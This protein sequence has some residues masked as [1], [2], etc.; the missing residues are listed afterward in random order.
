MRSITRNTALLIVTFL[1]TGVIQAADVDVKDIPPLWVA[2]HNAVKTVRYKA[3]GTQLFTTAML[4]MAERAPQQQDIEVAEAFNVLFD[5]Q[6]GR[7]RAE[8]NTHAAS[9]TGPVIIPLAQTYAYNGKQFQVFYPREENTTKSFKP[10]VD[11]PDLIVRNSNR[12]MILPIELRPLLWAQGIVPLPHAPLKLS[13]FG[14]IPAVDVTKLQIHGTVKIGD[15]D[16]LVVRTTPLPDSIGANY[17]EFCIDMGRQRAIVKATMYTRGKPIFQYD[18]E[19]SQHGT[20]WAP[21]KWTHSMHIGGNL[22]RTYQF[23]V[24]RIDIECKVEDSDF[25]F[26]LKPGMLVAE[27]ENLQRV[28]ANGRLT[29]LVGEEAARHAKRRELAK[30]AKRDIP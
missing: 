26:P 28:D 21:K 30:R 29:D 17:D 4:N 10:D 20:W 9:A 25:T 19:Y 13:D 8:S 15:R 2:R 22:M 11:R 18:V 7:F 6:R 24:T 23:T 1:L 5:T 27:G 16:C 3:S 12:T 14:A